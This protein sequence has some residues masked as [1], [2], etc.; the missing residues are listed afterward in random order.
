MIP[1]GISEGLYLFAAM[2]ASEGFVEL[3][4]AFGF[5]FHVVAFLLSFGGFSIT[6]FENAVKCGAAP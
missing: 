1:R 6:Q 5:K 4:E 3:R 2:G